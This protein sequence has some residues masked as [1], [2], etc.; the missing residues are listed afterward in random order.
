MTIRG[1]LLRGV[2]VTLT[3]NTGAGVV[4]GLHPSRAAGAALLGL[5]VQT[6]MGW[7]LPRPSQR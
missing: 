3:I 5:A 4:M 6:L 7:L 2:V 1:W